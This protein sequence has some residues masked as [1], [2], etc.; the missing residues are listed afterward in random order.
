MLNIDVVLWVISY[1]HYNLI[2]MFWG[3]CEES[4]KIVGK[5]LEMA[6][7]GRLCASSVWFNVT[8]VGAIILLAGSFGLQNTL[9]HP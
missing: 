9:R 3:S 8:E 2:V 7:E 6:D 5:F 4:V 1:L